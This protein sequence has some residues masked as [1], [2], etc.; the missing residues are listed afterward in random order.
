MLITAWLQP[1]RLLAGPDGAPGMRLSSMFLIVFILRLLQHIILRKAKIDKVVTL[2]VIFRH[3][4]QKLLTSIYCIYH[5]YNFNWFSRFLYYLIWSSV[6]SP[7]T[8]PI[9]VRDSH[10]DQQE[11]EEGE[12]EARHRVDHCRGERDGDLTES[13][14]VTCLEWTASLDL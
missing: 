14:H 11:D 6:I 9:T 8:L 5:L 7:C 10:H 2:R 3:R 1:A 13:W 4:Q 12:D